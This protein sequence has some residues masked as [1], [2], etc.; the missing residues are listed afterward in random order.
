M[1]WFT[2]PPLNTVAAGEEEEQKELRGHSVKF[3][4][5]KARRD[6]LI[7]EKRKM[8]EEGVDEGRVRKEARVEGEKWERERREVE[9]GALGLLEGRMRERTED[10]YRALYGER[11]RAEL[12]REMVRLG[13]GA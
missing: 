2:T 10:A 8:V 12:D 3:L 13:G 11:W 5:A 1:L 9:E 7:G 6:R 4:A